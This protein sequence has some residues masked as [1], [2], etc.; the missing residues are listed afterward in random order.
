MLTAQVFEGYSGSCWSTTVSTCLLTI[1]S[2]LAP[3][4]TVN[5]C[6]IQMHLVSLS[7]VMQRA[8]KCHKKVGG[9]VAHGPPAAELK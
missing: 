3:Q 2:V 1:T 6:I 8:V 9:A 4:H 7:S 5:A